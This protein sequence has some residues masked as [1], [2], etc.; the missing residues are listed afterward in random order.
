[1]NVGLQVQHVS[2]GELAARFQYVINAR[3]PPRSFP[4]HADRVGVLVWSNPAIGGRNDAGRWIV[5]VRQLV[6]WNI[7]SPL[8][9]VVGP[10]DRKAAVARS[11]DRY[12]AG[13]VVPDV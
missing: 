4:F 3:G 1:M 11:P 12:L 13:S 9:G 6:E 8:V 7:G 5:D 10:T 2:G